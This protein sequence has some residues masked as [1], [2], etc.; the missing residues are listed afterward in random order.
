MLACL[1]SNDTLDDTLIW[2]EMMRKNFNKFKDFNKKL[3]EELTSEVHA[4]GMRV[5][6]ANFSFRLTSSQDTFFM[7]QIKSF[8]H[9][10]NLN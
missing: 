1:E 7:I 2:H 9:G 10:F 4:E 6:P 5:E 8:S 3:G